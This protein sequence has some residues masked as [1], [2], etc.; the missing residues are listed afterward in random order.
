MIPASMIPA[1][2]IPAVLFAAAMLWL[3][4]SPSWAQTNLGAEAQSEIAGN[5]AGK[6][7]K[8]Q[9]E[10]TAESEQE[11]PSAEGEKGDMASVFA[12][13]ARTLHFSVLLILKL[14]LLFLT[15]LMWVSAGDWVNRDTQIHKLGWHK[16]NPILYFP[17]ALITLALFF[18]PLPV[19][20]KLPI[21][22]VV[23]LGTWVPYVLVH[24]KNVEPHETVLTA[25]WWRYV[26]ANF[27]S[28]VGIKVDAE[29]KA[30]YE[31]G[32]PVE[33]LA[34]GAEDA[35]TNNANLLSAR[36]S[37]G[38]LLAKDLIVEMKSKRSDRMLLDFTK[39]SV[40][41]RHEIDGVWHAGEPRERESNDV[42]LAVMKTLANLNAKERKKK[43]SGEFGA[44]YQGKT[45]VCPLVTQ[46]VATGERVIVTLSGEKKK[47]L[48]YN[49]LGMREGLQER[50]SELMASEQGFLVLSSLPGD[51]M[52]TITNISIGETDR[53][54]RDFV[55]IEEVN[56][57][58]EEI[59]NL[60]ITTFDSAAE[61]SPATILPKLIRT[62]PNVYVCRDLV[63]VESA[64]LLLGEVR[65]E[66]LVITNIRARESGEALLRLLQMKIPA[67]E[68]ASA[69]KAVL[70]QRL[71]RLLCPDCK[72]VYTPPTEMLRK[73]GIPGGKIEQLYRPPK[74]EEI[75]KPCVTCQGLGYKGRTG[76]FELLVITDQMRELL[77]K[78]PKL[79]LL[80][81][82]AR[83]SRQ[84]SLQEEGI[85]LVA[86]GITSVPELMRVLKQ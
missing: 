4:P 81:K 9:Q 75:N 82:A 17:F 23:F 68:L 67:K 83:A 41:V 25:P 12:E 31:K 86:K 5:G 45:Y 26:F 69:V 38:Y 27:G 55:A 28:K 59:Q 63:N 48:S 8:K 3:A 39:Q 32:A 14:L 52:T 35:N 70:Y 53:L 44:K 33:L 36:H 6:G 58:E 51:G 71:I 65:D 78:Q 37:P 79:P 46:G 16:W 80:K 74:G 19:F 7:E 43:Q 15:I 2:T 34:M 54:M 20:I 40:N 73:L 18:L 57:G 60:K 10:K 56:H 77:V 49:D 72:V 42:M 24:N 84:R 62:Y 61:E 1:S 22:L 13:Q 85:L 76:V 64:K 66:H 29:R 50:W 21:L 11:K 47:L 30:E